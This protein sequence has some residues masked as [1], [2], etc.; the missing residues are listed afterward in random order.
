[1][2]MGVVGNDG[3]RFAM[4]YRGRD[5][6]EPKPR[7]EKKREKKRTET[8]ETENDE[9]LQRIFLIYEQRWAEVDGR[10]KRFACFGA[11]GGTARVR[12]AS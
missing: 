9:L 8:E 4:R 12:Y 2:A 11:V 3:R 7:E 5:H 1:M 10:K 6:N